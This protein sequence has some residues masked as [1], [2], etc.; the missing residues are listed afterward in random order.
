MSLQEKAPLSPTGIP[1]IQSRYAQPRHRG[2]AD[3]IANW[4]LHASALI[5]AWWK[6][7]RERRALARLDDRMLQDIGITREQ[8]RREVLRPFWDV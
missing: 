3:R 2:V 5:E 4:L 1:L 8:A 7:A 6:T